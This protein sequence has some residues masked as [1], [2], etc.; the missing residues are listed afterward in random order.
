MQP[1]ASLPFSQGPSSGPY[2]ET[3][4]QYISTH[5]HFNIIHPPTPWSSQWLFPS[6]I[7][8]TEYRIPASLVAD[9]L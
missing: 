6:G 8:T 3:Y 7:P 1:E 5:I 4:I 2:P 9:L